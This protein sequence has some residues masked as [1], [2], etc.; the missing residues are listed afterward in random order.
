MAAFNGPE[1]SGRSADD[2][3][4]ERIVGA[5]YD[6]FARCGVP[7][8]GVNRIIAEAGVAKTTLYR[9]FE[10]KDD[11]AIATLDR[12]RE[13]WTREWFQREIERRGET[14]KDRL[15]AIFELFDE[16]FRRDDYSG[17]MFTNGLLESHDRS[18]AIGAS[19]IGGLA[20]VRSVLE[21]LAE[22]AG[23]REPAALAHQWQLLMWGSMVSASAG[24]VGAARVARDAAVT[25][26]AAGALGPAVVA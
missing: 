21:A 23:A 4:R 2:G 14:A 26:L 6:L 25:L 19:C 22:E 13:L 11:L 20:E 17:C 3:P 16:W 18:G 1:V 8:V 15:L 5:A 9:H 10:S 12:R 7:G 24:E